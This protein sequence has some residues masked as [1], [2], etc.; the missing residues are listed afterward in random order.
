MAIETRGRSNTLVVLP[1]AVPVEQITD[2][3]IDRNN[4][5][6]ICN[7][8]PVSVDDV[9][10]CIDVMADSA[11]PKHFKGGITLL[12]TGSDVDLDIQTVSVND[13]VFF[14]MISFGHSLKPEALDFDQIYNIGLVQVIRDIYTDLSQEQ[15]HFESSDLHSTVYDALLAEVGDQDP[16]QILAS[17]RGEN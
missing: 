8:F 1:S 11:K 9:F 3:V 7:R 2:A 16:H 12:N 10:E 17:L 6:W 5:D 14:S 13:T 15:Y 4:L